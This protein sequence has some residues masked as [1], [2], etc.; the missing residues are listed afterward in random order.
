MTKEESRSLVFVSALLV[1]ATF[2]R[3]ATKPKPMTITASPIDLAAFRA[4]NEAMLKQEPANSRSRRHATTAT[5]TH[6]STAQ[7][8]RARKHQP[9]IFIETREPPSARSPLN[10]NRAGAKEL[11]AL[12]GVGP[13]MAKRII[14]RRDSIGGF[15][16]V[17]DL[18]AVRGIGPKFIE[19]IKP[20]VLVR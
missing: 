12:P 6:D 8:N 4:A 20:L 7:T 18:D 15:R 17:E 19:R 2:A 9:P 11:E 5:T 3:V 13:A 16:K 14:A 10:L 1:L